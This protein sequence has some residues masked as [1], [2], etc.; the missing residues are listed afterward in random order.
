[1]GQEIKFTG[2]QHLGSLKRMR[3]APEGGNAALTG[4]VVSAFNEST[5]FVRLLIFLETILR[6]L[7]GFFFYVK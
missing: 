1:M 6:K 2:R 7:V 4:I 3:Y 5:K